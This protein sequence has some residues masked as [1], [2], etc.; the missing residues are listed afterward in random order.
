MMKIA[1]EEL[2][3]GVISGAFGEVIEHFV[4]LGSNPV[5]MI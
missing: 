2:K 4:P 3:A 1:L 5:R